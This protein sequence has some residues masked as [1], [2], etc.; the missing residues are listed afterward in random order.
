MMINSIINIIVEGGL[1]YYVVDL[2]SRVGMLERRLRVAD[3]LEE[4][5][6]ASGEQLNRMGMIWGV[7]REE[8]EPDD[9][10]RRRVLRVI[11]KGLHT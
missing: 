4:A 11:R 5:G 1:L 10:Y 3:D 2:R 6:A 9:I 7:Y 8:F